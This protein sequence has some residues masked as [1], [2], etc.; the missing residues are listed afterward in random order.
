MRY[1]GAKVPLSIF[2]LYKGSRKIEA[3][4]ARRMQWGAE[5][6]GETLIWTVYGSPG[7]FI[8]RPCMTLDGIT[9]IPVHLEAPTIEE[10]RDQLPPG[11]T[12][13]DRRPEDDPTV[14]ETW[15]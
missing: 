8:A 11:L 9:P 13:T 12:R 7:Q 5:Y 10:L 6:V 15:Q 3:T 1:L 2:G 4:P 14:I